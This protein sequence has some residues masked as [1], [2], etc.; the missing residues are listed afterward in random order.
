MNDFLSGKDV[1]IRKLY[2]VLQNKE[3]NRALKMIEILQASKYFLLMASFMVKQISDIT[4]DGII[5][6]G[7]DAALSI[8]LLIV[9][10]VVLCFD[11]YQ[12]RKYNRNVIKQLA[13]E[14]QKRGEKFES[15]IERQMELSK[16]QTATN[17][18]L[19]KSIEN[20]SRSLENIL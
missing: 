9:A 17:K 6:K 12:Y 16:D 7:F 10:L 20:L 11:Y 18:E 5:S 3:S 1:K 14:N 19:V 8:G 13:A 15:I 2:K 4:P